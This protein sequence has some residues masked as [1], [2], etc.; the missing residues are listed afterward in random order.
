MLLTYKYI[1]YDTNVQFLFFFLL[2]LVDILLQS[3]QSDEIHKPDL[4][5][6]L[7]HV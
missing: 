3:R 6:F 2:I 7:P 1:R 4:V 5:T